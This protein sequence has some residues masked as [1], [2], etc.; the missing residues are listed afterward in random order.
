M[1]LRGTVF[2]CQDNETRK[3]E[4]MLTCVNIDVPSVAR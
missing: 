3:Q 4:T 1:F 2:W